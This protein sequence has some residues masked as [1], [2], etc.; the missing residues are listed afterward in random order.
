M[1]LS[2]KASATDDIKTELKKYLNRFDDTFENWKRVK[3][4]LYELIEDGDFFKCSCPYGVKKY[5][6]KHAIGLSIKLK[7]F[8]SP[9]NAKSVPLAEKR[10]RGRPVKNKGWWSRE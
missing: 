9:D 2:K 6:C 1:G 4:V 8:Q 5:F 10:K 3:S 7:N